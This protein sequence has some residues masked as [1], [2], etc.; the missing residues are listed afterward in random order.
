MKNLYI[1]AG[2]SDGYVGVYYTFH[3]HLAE[4]FIELSDSDDG[5]YSDDPDYIFVPE[6]MTYED[7]GITGSLIEDMMDCEDEL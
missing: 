4:R 3:R 6:E 5:T 1:V 7:L 2:G